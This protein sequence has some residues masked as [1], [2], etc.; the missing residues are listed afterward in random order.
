MS[1][2]RARAR[3]LAFG[4][5]AD[6]LS[7]ASS[8]HSSI[9]S[10]A[11]STKEGPVRHS[12]SLSVP[13]SCGSR[14]N[15]KKPVHVTP[16]RTNR[17]RRI[18]RNQHFEQFVEALEQDGCVIVEDFV[19]PQISQRVQSAE[20]ADVEEQVDNNQPRLNIIDVNSLIRESLTSDSLFQTLSSHFLALE[21]ISWQDR[22]IDLRS[23]K[24]HISSSRT[25]D[26][27]EADIDASCFH[28][29]DSK[30]HTKHTATSKYEYRSRR[31]TN[32]GL[33]VP[34]IDSLSST[35]DISVI[36]G[37]HLW[38][39]QKPDISQGIKGLQLKGGDA[40]IMLGSLYH[41]IP[42][43]ATSFT[44]KALSP[45]RSRKGSIKEKLMHEIWMCSGIYRPA[46]EIVSDDE[47]I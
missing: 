1:S 33:V 28:R 42:Q 10:A 43:N 6:N 27:N 46:D 34:E 3:R 8:T 25:H 14:S 24:P 41:E 11:S 38:D 22:S 40:L 18:H 30:H 47:E 5:S 17:V 4:D 7:D 32:I 44:E 37:S 2:F 39:D 9:H 15:S 13:C 21:T 45:S 35:I 31:E 23:T 19:N 29:A 26:L 16:K 20:E 12:S 36:P